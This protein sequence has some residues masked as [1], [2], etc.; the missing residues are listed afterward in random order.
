MSNSE[1]TCADMPQRQEDSQDPRALSP[2]TLAFLGDAVYEILVRSYL[3]RNYH[4]SPAK[5]HRA[6]IGFVNAA[7]QARAVAGILPTL[8]DEERGILRRGRNASTSHIPKNAD[9]LDYRHATGLEALFGSLYLSGKTARINEIFTD[10]LSLA[11]DGEPK[12]R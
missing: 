2:V 5:L 6:S 7:A 1:V 12:S 4:V 9:V 3:V 11:Q 10:I 8:T